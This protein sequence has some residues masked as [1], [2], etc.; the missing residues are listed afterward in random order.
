MTKTLQTINNE[1]L[2]DHKIGDNS[3][4]PTVCAIAWMADAA[5]TVYDN[6]Q[7]I[8][9][10]NYKLFKGVVFD[11]TEASDYYIDLNLI[12]ENN[13]SL[14][15][16][17]KI[18]STSAKGKPVFHYGAKVLLNHRSIKMP[19]AL[20]DFNE[21][22]A[23]DLSSENI[24]DA[25]R[26]YHDGTLF[27]GDSL[28]GIKEVISCDDNGLLLKCLVPESAKS[29]QGDFPL[30]INNIFAND[31]VYQAMLVW[32]RKQLGM[33]SLP[34]STLKWT[35]Y[36]QVHADETFY[37]KLKVVEQ[38]NSKLIADISLISTDNE[39]LAEINAA[40][41]TASENLNDLF[42]RS[43]AKVSGL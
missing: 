5:E 10:E 7:Y 33:G 18:S 11:G 38:S 37:L 16:D 4:M 3:V 39:L 41:V 12:D 42:M 2:A 20:I 19:L 35:T 9:V 43:S 26:L 30:E 17:V 36:R 14:T 29:K 28:Q 40:E 21:S 13:Q 23:S 34:S 32:V 1:F 15:L 31:L 25:N 8:G 27:H 22:I 24:G 6:Y